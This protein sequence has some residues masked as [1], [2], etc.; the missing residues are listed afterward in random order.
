MRE[1]LNSGRE[2]AL[3]LGPNELCGRDAWPLLYNL[4]QKGWLERIGLKSKGGQIVEM[5]IILADEAPR[6]EVRRFLDD[7]QRGAGGGP[8]ETGTGIDIARSWS[9]AKT[10]RVEQEKINR[11]LSLAGELIINSNGLVYLIRRLENLGIPVEV[12][13]ELKDYQASLTRTSWGLQDTVMEMR[14][15]PV[16]LVFERFRRVIRELGHD[17][18]KKARLKTRGDKVTI[19]RNVAA[20]IYEPLLHLVRNALD[21]GLELPPER[22][23]AG[24]EEE[25]EI[26]LA[27]WKRGERVVITVKDDG[28]GIDEGALK[29][30]ALR[31]GLISEEQ[32]GK[33]SYQ[34]ALELVFHPGFSTREVAGEISGRG[35]GMDV[36]RETVRG[37]GGKVSIWSQPGQGTETRLEIP[38]TM[39]VTKI[40]LLECGG[41]YGIPVGEIKEIV[42]VKIDQIHHLKNKEV[43]ALRDKLYP[44]LRLGRLLGSGEAGNREA[45]EMVLVVLLGGL[46]IEVGRIIGEQDVVLKNLPSQLAGISLFS[47]AAV[48]GSGEIALILNGGVLGG[49]V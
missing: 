12:I 32:A 3:K 43:V 8:E 11:L 39:S 41:L 30:K 35:V 20:A 36:V 4:E 31:L 45:D 34:E 24:K 38:V 33:M 18:G 7:F 6:E 28:R 22:L 2:N 16:G 42:R 14:L 5:E 10:V 15:M 46:T 13:R 1:L 27:A 47:G 25:G 21:H 23:A 19:D 40:L 44:L 49:M 48:L 17:L 29:S 9:G 37:L 26:E